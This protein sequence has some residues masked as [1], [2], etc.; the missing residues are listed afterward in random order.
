MRRV[1]LP[2]GVV[3]CL[4]CDRTYNNDGLLAGPGNAATAMEP[5]TNH[6]PFWDPPKLKG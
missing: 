2:G 6:G 4:I 5:V 3:A 1:I